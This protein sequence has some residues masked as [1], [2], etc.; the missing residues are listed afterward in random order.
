MG[1]VGDGGIPRKVDILDS[2]YIH[3][4]PVHKNN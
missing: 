4:G 2:I 1:G 3:T